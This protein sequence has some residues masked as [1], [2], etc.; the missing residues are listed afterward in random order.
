MGKYDKI[1]EPVTLGKSCVLKNRIIKA[2]QSSWLWNEDGS[3]GDSGPRT[4]TRAWRKAA[5]AR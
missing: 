4:C 5:W 3:M 2:P 1:F